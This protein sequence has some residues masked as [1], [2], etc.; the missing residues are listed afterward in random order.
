MRE[1]GQA[2]ER[3]EGTICKA[4]CGCCLFTSLAGPGER[5]IIV[6]QC[7][8]TGTRWNAAFQFSVRRGRTP[9]IRP[10][11]HM[12]VHVMRVR[13]PPARSCGVRVSGGGLKPVVTR[14]PAD[15]KL[16]PLV[17]TFVHKADNLSVSHR[18]SAAVSHGGFP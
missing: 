17:T 12:H 9:Y 3:G 4:T 2:S 10:C 11:G 6:E 5:G 15:L 13:V 1:R 7:I 14:H 16:N 18:V 8:S